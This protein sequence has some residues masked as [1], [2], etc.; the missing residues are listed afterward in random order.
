MSCRMLPVGFSRPCRQKKKKGLGLI[1]VI[2]TESIPNLRAG[3]PNSG[4]QLLL[5]DNSSHIYDTRYT[6]GLIQV[7]VP[8]AFNPESKYPPPP[9]S[10]EGFLGAPR[11]RTWTS[12]IFKKKC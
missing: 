1:F 4:L 7:T 6:T 3:T 8:V 2:R 12:S 5:K 9:K 10:T 11:T